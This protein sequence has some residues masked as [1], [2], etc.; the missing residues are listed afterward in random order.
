MFQSYDAKTNTDKAIAAQVRALAGHLM[1]RSAAGEDI[2]FPGTDSHDK[3]ANIVGCYQENPDSNPTLELK[4]YINDVAHFDSGNVI[5]YS[6]GKAIDA[7]DDA[8]LELTDIH[9]IVVEKNDG[10]CYLL[11]QE[12]EYGL[13]DTEWAE[14]VAY[15]IQALIEPTVYCAIAEYSR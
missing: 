14:V 13:T 5:E 3:A 6:V 11:I 7:S 12:E 4:W 2:T 8:V 1:G 10:A 9:A 15:H